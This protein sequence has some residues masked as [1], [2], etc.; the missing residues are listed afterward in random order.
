MAR[1]VTVPQSSVEKLIFPIDWEQSLLEG[2]EIT[3]VT[4][5]HTPPEGGSPASFGKQIASPISYIKSPLSLGVGKHYVS[6]VATTTNSDL[7]PEVYIV[8]NVER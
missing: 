3:D 4:I 5:T 8:I 2:V 1:R 7:A 6:V